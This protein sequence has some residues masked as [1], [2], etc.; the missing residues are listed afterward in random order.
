MTQPVLIALLA[1]AIAVIFAAAIAIVTLAAET[2]S[3]AVKLVGVGAVIAFAVVTLQRANLRINFTGSMPIGVYLL[4]PSQ[5]NGV[6]R[7]MLIAGCAPTRA[8]EIGRQRGYLGAGP[9][10][11]N[12][13][14]LLK[15]VVAIAGDEVDVTPA[16]VAVNGC[17]L[18]HSRPDAR[19]RAG[20]PLGSWIRRHY[21]LA[22]PQ[23]WLYAPNARS[24]DSRYWGPVSIADI[25][26][27]AV[28]LLAFTGWSS[29]SCCPSQASRYPVI[30][31]SCEMMDRDRNPA[32][33]NSCKTHLPI[34][35]LEHSRGTC[36]RLLCMGKLCLRADIRKR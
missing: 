24:W 7:G 23:V 20:R 2:L 27:E 18:L 3:R 16:G 36:N 29:V 32:A 34:H 33:R 4:L 22:S 30:L 1:L 6:K 9:C 10:A 8:A 31:D 35:L 25:K 5:P 12:T 11:E 14:L 13:E 17:V 19:D 21:R 28:P 15:S 26:A